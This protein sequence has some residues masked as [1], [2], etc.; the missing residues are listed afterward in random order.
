[1]KAHDIICLH[2]MVGTL[3][4][5]DRYFLDN[6]YAGNESHFGVGHDGE[7]LQWQDLDYT[8]D[9]NYGG[10][11]HIIS[12]ETADI[13]TGFPTWDI[14]SGSQVPPWTDAQIDRLADLVAWCC[15]QY[16]IPCVIIPD[17]KTGRRGVGYHR[18]GV[19]NKKGATLSQT[20]G[21]LW[22]N[23]TGKVCPGDARIAQIPTIVS[24]ARKI[25][26]APAPSPIPNELKQ[27]MESEDQM[28]IV[29]VEIEA[30]LRYHVGIQVEAGAGSRI[31]KGAW[32]CMGSMWGWTDVL[33]TAHDG[34]GKV[35]YQWRQPNGDLYRVAD[36]RVWPLELGAG[37]RLVSVEG[38][39]EHEDTRPSFSLYHVPL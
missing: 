29:P 25:L 34:A 3:W 32:L 14:R 28:A 31:A 4:G 39:V 27:A 22:S 37:T 5:T 26:G 17:S 24:K 8:A 35:L 13:G 6:G 33:V 2:T 1:M 19:P 36:N 18:Q 11:N 15:K 7:T 38:E 10:N 9:A 20:G 21:E 30:D 12:I 23:S 16:D